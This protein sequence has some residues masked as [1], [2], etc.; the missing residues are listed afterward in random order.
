MNEIF[1][2]GHST[3]PFDAF[4]KLLHAH[5]IQIL[6]DIRTV[7]KSLHNPQYAQ[8]NLAPALARENIRYAHLQRLGGLRKAKPDSINLGWENASFRGYADYMQTPEFEQGLDELIALAQEGRVAMMCAEGNPFR[9]HRQLVADALTARGIPVY[10]IVSRKTARL[11]E[12]N[13]RAAVANQRV[14][15]PAPASA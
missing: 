4:V 10:H 14:T 3:R 12:L 13:P 11:H 8:A 9:C 2:I 1:A 5:D 7:P 15:Y 6:A